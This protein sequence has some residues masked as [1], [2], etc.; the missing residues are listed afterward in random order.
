MKD[1][2]INNIVPIIESNAADV[3]LFGAGAL[4][5]LA[6]YALKTIGINADYFCDSDEKKQGKLYCGIKTIS[7]KD[8]AKLSQVTHIFICNDYITSVYSLL[9]QM[10][11]INIYNCRVLFENTDFSTAALDM[12]PLDIQRQIAFHKNACLKT[13][14]TLPDVLNLT[15]IDIVVTECCSLKCR[16]CA[17]LMQYY[18]KPKHCDLNLL[19]KSVRKF[20]DC[21]DSLYE[22][23]VLGGEAFMNKQLH[24]IVN[25]LLTYKN[26]EKV[27]VYSN[28]TIIPKGEN[29]SC[30][31]NYNVIVDITNYGD[32]S[33][34]YQELIEVLKANH[35]AYMIKSVFEWTKSASIQ[36]H[37]RT[38]SELRRIFMDCC[39][40]DTITLL[41]GKLYRCPF[42]AHATNLKAIPFNPDDT[43][44]LSDENLSSSDLKTNIKRFYNDKRYISA[45]YYCNGRA[46]NCA[47]TMPAI[48]IKKPLPL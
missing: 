43:I 15:S 38:T 30:L 45:C 36:Y 44:D 14:N 21:I 33:N 9:K 25:E 6:L 42:S 19:F 32:I 1:Y 31:K 47:K 46:Y 20:M 23:R 16:D 40:N 17:N 29:F 41:H 11:F 18:V 37:Q 28:G 12:H 39:A 48:Q 7:P 10:N 2:N 4:G 35:I 8:L 22:F 34:K 27:V 24:K 5:K 26:A 3:V 13:A